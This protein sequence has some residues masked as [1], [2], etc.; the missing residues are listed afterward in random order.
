MRIKSLDLW[1]WLFPH[2]ICQLGSYLWL[3]WL[4]RYFRVGTVVC[5]VFILYAAQL[6]VY[7]VLLAQGKGHLTSRLSIYK[8]VNNS[9]QF[10]KWKA[11]WV[12]PITRKSNYSSPR[13]R[14]RCFQGLTK[15]PSQTYWVESSKN[16]RQPIKL[17]PDPSNVYSGPCPWARGSL[18]MI[19]DKDTASDHNLE[20][21]KKQEESQD[22]TFSGRMLSSLILLKHYPTIEAIWQRTILKYK[23]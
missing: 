13:K 11:C 17:M 3:T 2:M 19:Y 14:W 4:I 23:R 15:P 6:P 16:W 1:T 20:R 21:Q 12:L 9:L 7:Q 5:L 18:G 10:W 22:T 8:P